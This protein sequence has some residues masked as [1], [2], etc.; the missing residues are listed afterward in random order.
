[1]S[2]ITHDLVGFEMDGDVAILTLSNPPVNAFSRDLVSAF[3]DA[4]GKVEGSGARALLTRANGSNFSA[5]ADP[6][7]FE[8]L[9]YVDG[10]LLVAEL[11]GTIQRFESLPIPTI[12]AVRGMTVAAGL[13]LMLAH[14]IVYA[15]TGSMFGQVEAR[16][17]TATLAGGAQRVALRSGIARAKEMVFTGGLFDAETCL[18]WGLINRVIKPEELD[19]KSL[20]F[21]HRLSKGPTV[22]L[23]AD[24]AAFGAFARAQLAPADA[25][26][27]G[28]AGTT[29]VS[30]DMRMGLKAFAEG[31]A[32]AL[33]QKLDFAGS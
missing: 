33:M 9:G 27:I 24:K 28:A 6:S 26:M 21:A 3:Q 32:A 17:G 29:F 1:M 15:A 11:I 19:D 10:S 18:S 22:A 14:D 31:G 23:A 25:A 12:C 7:M 5:G 16:L 13:E 2:K 20:R 8:G 30:D 4:V